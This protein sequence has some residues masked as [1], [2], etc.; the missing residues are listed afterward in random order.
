M[1]LR[2]SRKEKDTL[3]LTIVGESSDGLHAISPGK[4]EGERVSDGEEVNGKLTLKNIRKDFV[5]QSLKD[6]IRSSRTR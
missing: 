4:R 1:L 2:A 6:E 5:E 3:P